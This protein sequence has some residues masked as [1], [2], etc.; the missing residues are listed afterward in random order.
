MSDFTGRKSSLGDEY[1]VF[2]DQEFVQKLPLKRFDVAIH[3]LLKVAVPLHL[4]LLNQHRTNI[5]KFQQLSE[6]NRLDKEMI[7]ASR[8]VQQLKADIHDMDLI[9]SQIINTDLDSF[10][11]KVQDAKE[12][13]LK[14]VQSFIDLHVEVTKPVIGDSHTRVGQAEENVDNRTRDIFGDSNDG[15]SEDMGASGVSQL[16][17]QDELPKREETRS[18]IW[19]N[20]KNSLV[21]LNEIMRSFASDVRGQK[22]RVDS[23]EDNIEYSLYNTKYG[24]RNL[25]KATKLKYAVAPVAGAVIGVCTG[26]PVGLLLGLKIGVAAAFG[27]S[28]IGFQTGRVIKKR[29]ETVTDLEMEKLS[30]PMK[31]SS[32]L[33]QVESD[34]KMADYNDVHR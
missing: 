30:N 24:V 6:W 28:L 18:R 20:L 17:I 25:S 2:T 8:T 16:R 15:C 3:K 1:V 19:L 34:L 33:P 21:D 23:I 14:C 9:R 22:E 32:S 7:N 4:E 29:N 27:G 31:R 12:N 13:A 11:L 26:G 10:D 5:E